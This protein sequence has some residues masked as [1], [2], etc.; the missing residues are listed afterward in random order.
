MATLQAARAHVLGLPFG[1]AASWGLNRAIF[2]AAAKRGFKGG[3]SAAG[4]RGSHT[5]AK[6]E[7]TERMPSE[8]Y[9]LGDELAFKAEGEG[10]LRFAIGG[11]AQTEE[12]FQGQI[13]ARFQ[14]RFKDA[15]EEAI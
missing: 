2:Y 7:A 3:S 13:G 9:H 6:G 10:E 5:G 14:G 11:K 1:S 12:D 15:W 4:P 8:A